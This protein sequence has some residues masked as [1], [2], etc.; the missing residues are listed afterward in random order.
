[1]FFYD[2][3]F[4]KTSIIDGGTNVLGCGDGQHVM[5]AVLIAAVCSQIRPVLECSHAALIQTHSVLPA[6]GL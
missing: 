2:D 3:C 1:M 5:P 4:R 6:E